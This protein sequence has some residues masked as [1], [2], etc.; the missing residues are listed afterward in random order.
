[1]GTKLFFLLFLINIFFNIVKSDS[2]GKVVCYY[3]SKA[4][5]REGN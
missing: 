1:M 2:S 3:D 4:V 5:S